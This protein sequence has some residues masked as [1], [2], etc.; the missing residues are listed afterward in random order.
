MPKKGKGKGKGKG[1]K[2][3]KKDKKALPPPV[4]AGTDD[5][6]DEMSK[7]FYTIQILVRTFRL[8]VE[9]L[10]FWFVSAGSGRTSLPLS[11]QV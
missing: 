11:G 7:R 4:D 6:V 8:R 9:L 1:K 10:W 3:G 2:K 5:V